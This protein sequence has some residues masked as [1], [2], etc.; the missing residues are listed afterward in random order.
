M[1]KGFVYILT[2]PCLDGWVKIGMTERNDIE[3]RLRELNAPPNIPLSYRCYAV[4]EV[5]D[6]LEVERRIHSI[7]DRVDDSLH[8]REHLENGRVRIREFFKISPETAY[9]IFKDIASLRGDTDKLQLYTPT[10]E[11]S[12]E[13]EIAERK[14]K[15]SNNSFKLLNIAVGE[16]IFFLYDEQVAAKVVND[17]NQIEYE[18][19]RYSVTALARKLLIEK[20]GWSENLHVNGWMYFIKDGISLSDLRDRIENTE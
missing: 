14:T 8:A 5:E 7:I 10:L 17:R 18:G 19:A 4:Y 6:P 9:G 3:S 20:H 1:A 16:E 12:Q 15:R 13:Q 2:N 11:Q